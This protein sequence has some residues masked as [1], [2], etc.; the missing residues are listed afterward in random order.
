[1]LSGS[2]HALQLKIALAEA[3][4]TGLHDFGGQFIIARIA[5]DAKGF[6]VFSA[7]GCPAGL[8]FARKSIGLDATQAILIVIEDARAAFD[9]FAADAI[10]LREI[11]A[12]QGI[13]IVKKG[14]LASCD[15]RDEALIVRCGVRHAGERITAQALVAE[16]EVVACS[17]GIRRNIDFMFLIPVRKAHLEVVKT[18]VRPKHFKC[19]PVD[20]D[21]RTKIHAGQNQLGTEVAG[22]EAGLAAAFGKLERWTSD[23]SGN[24]SGGDSCEA[25][26][27][28]PKNREKTKH[29]QTSLNVSR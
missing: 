29:E 21:I 24:R 14:L 28:E 5:F 3:R 22:Y 17:A 8:Y 16:I 13:F 25:A 11:H 7:V 4:D 19:V 9:G 23:E 1:M 20:E 12:G 6:G 15:C 2:I 10:P 18:I 26:D 27:E